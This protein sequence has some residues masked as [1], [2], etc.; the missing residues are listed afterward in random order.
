MGN[1]AKSSNAV[2]V[3][4]VRV[5]IADKQFGDHLGGHGYG[6]L[7]AKSALHCEREEL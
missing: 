5:S 7:D 6:G 3:I 4:A 2:T 1:R